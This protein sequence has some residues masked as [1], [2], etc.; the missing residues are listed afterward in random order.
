MTI[1]YVAGTLLTIDP[2]FKMLIPLA[3]PG[4][5]KLGVHLS[6]EINDKRRF[7]YS[8]GDFHGRVE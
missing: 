2:P 5:E 4:H 1:S 3:E 6:K 7:S 8:L